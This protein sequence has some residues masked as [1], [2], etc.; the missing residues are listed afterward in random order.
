MR[1]I[2]IFCFHTQQ[3]TEIL[4][5]SPSERLLWLPGSILNPKSCL[6]SF[7][8]NYPLPLHW[9]PVL[10]FRPKSATS[11][12][13][14]YFIRITNRKLRLKVSIGNPHWRPAGSN[15]PSV[16]LYLAQIHAGN[17]YSR[18]RLHCSLFWKRSEQKLWTI[19]VQDCFI[20][21]DPSG[22]RHCN[23]IRSWSN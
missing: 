22:S 11:E 4:I 21:L 19:Q 9:K 18:R 13:T 14:H 7:D 5:E 17:S 3:E 20:L 8:S 10:D 23:P 6:L 2:P 16:L 1:S 15:C 12:A